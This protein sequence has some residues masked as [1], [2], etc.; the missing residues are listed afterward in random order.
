M[1]T[2]IEVE[3]TPEEWR[4]FF[5]MP[6]VSEVNDELI[7]QTKEKIASGEYD[8]LAMMKQFMPENMQKIADM[9]KNFWENLFQQK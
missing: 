7:K 2:K 6:D 5:G 8:P 1:K 9:Q 3:A 4:R